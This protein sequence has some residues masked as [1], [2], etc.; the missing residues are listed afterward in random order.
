MDNS[1]FKIGADAWWMDTTEPETEAREE[2]VMVTNK[3][4]SAAARVT[5]TSFRC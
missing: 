1:L 2:S 4:R 5:R 3:S